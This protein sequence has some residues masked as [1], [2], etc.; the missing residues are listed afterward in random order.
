MA[1]WHAR[2]T[3]G[4]EVRE[5]DILTSEATTHLDEDVGNGFHWAEIKHG[6]GH[7]DRKTMVNMWFMEGLTKRESISKGRAS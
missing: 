5:V 1:D 3:Q 4:L 2:D 7:L 6:Q